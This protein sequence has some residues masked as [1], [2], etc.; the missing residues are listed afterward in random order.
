VTKL[1]KCCLV[2]LGLVGLEIELLIQRFRWGGL[3]D[4][5]S[6]EVV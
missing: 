6:F 5:V 1:M 3:W 4:L 2:H